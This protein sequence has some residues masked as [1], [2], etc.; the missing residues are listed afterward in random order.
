MQGKKE[1][2][3]FYAQALRDERAE[4]A[5]K[6]SVAAPLATAKG[7]IRETPDISA[8]AWT[9]IPSASLQKV[10]LDCPES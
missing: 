2:R 8:M 6:D 5:F 9:A 4:L 7:G 3:C 10:S 1:K